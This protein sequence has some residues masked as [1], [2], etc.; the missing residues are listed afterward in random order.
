MYL[1]K[2]TIAVNKAGFLFKPSRCSTENATMGLHLGELQRCHEH[3]ERQL[4][5]HVHPVR[6]PRL[7]PDRSPS[8]QRLIRRAALAA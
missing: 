1:R 3:R 6:Q 8:Q 4:G 7:R 5:T 2:L